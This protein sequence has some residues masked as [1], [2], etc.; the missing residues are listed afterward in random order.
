MSGSAL[1]VIDVQQSFLHR[2]Y[3]DDTRLPPFRH[4]LLALIAGARARGVPVVYVLH[5][6]GDG[7]FAATSGHVQP[8][9]W[10]P[11]AP[12]A[13]FT[14]HVHNAFTDTGLQAWLAARGVDRLIISGIR[15]EQCCETTTR[16]GSDLGFTVDFV[17]EATLTF[18]MTH[19][20][21]GR[22]YSA[23]DI[24]QRTELVL[25]GRFAHIH[26]VASVLARLDADAANS[27]IL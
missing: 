9:A 15:T 14:K 18:D 7:P 13:S 20:H 6:D 23:D 25:A 11:P 19:P 21:S 8:M 4:A 24:C 3:W 10:L 22:V 5:E 12:D 27:T 16:V 26:T 17:T 2:S 1:I